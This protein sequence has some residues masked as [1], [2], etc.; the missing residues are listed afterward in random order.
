MVNL[1]QLKWGSCDCRYNRKKANSVAEEKNNMVKKIRYFG[2]MEWC[3]N[4]EGKNGRS[5]YEK[6]I[7]L[8][9]VQD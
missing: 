2:R 6:R 1:L 4:T 9:H 5:Q 8:K 7:L 3:D